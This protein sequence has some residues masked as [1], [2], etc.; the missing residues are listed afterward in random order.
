LENKIGAK[1]LGTL[2]EAMKTPEGAAALLETL[3]ASE[4]IRVLKLISDPK[5]WA[6]APT[7]AAAIGVTNALAPPNENRIQ[8][9]NMMPGRP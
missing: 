6:R 8:L 7:G 9:N 3:P 5:S 2:T 1:T 4:R